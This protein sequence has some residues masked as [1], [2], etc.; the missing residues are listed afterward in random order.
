VVCAAPRL[1][2]VI[3]SV[4][5]AAA[6]VIDSCA[7]TVCTGDPLSLTATVKVDVPLPVGVPEITPPL[8]S[9][10]PT[11]RVP[12][13]SDH[14]YPGVPPVALSVVL[15]ELPFLPPAGFADVIDSPEAE[16]VSDSCSVA[17]CAGDPLSVTATVNVAVPVAAGVPVILPAFESVNPA[18]RLPDASDHVYPGVPPVSLRVVL[19]EL[20]FVPAPRLVDVIDRLAAEIVS[21]SCSETVC[22]GDP[23]S[24]TATVKVAV[25]VAVGVPEITPAFESVN[26][27][28]KLPDASDHVYP[29]VPPVALSVALYEL[30]FFPTARL[31]DVIDSPEAEIVS[32]SCADAVSAGDA[33]SVT[34]T[35]KVAVPLAVG[36]PEITPALESVSPAGKLPDASDHVYPGVPPVAL[37]VVAYELPTIPVPRLRVR[38][39]R[40]GGTTV[41]DIRPDTDCAGDPLSVAA[42]VKEDV[43]LVVGVP[44]ITPP[45]DSVSP[46]GRV[47]DTRDHV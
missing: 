40:P 7:E 36:V 1:V 42:I 34:A 44:E 18:G 16:I 3:V 46:A 20:P 41:M 19:Y 2:D 21:D 13:A 24:L 9:V 45:P 5:G 37:S 27:A 29:G 6:T 23:L 32:D 39:A 22:T 30:P 8:D 47:P 38:T 11:G 33:L 4:A 14:V 15:Y 26:P 43:P 25:P 31:V 12:D 17:V 10:R 35:V 28:G